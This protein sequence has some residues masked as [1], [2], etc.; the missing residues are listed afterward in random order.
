MLTNSMDKKKLKDFIE[1]GLSQR[2]IAKK[3]GKSQSTVRHWLDKYEITKPVKQI[4]IQ[5]CSFCGSKIHDKKNPNRSY[6]SNQCQQLAQREKAISDGVASHRSLKTHLIQERG[7][8]CEICKI[9]EWCGE[10]APLILDHVD[11]NSENNNI[12]NLRLVC[13]NCD[14]QLPTYK[15]KNKGNGRHNRRQR[16]EIGKSY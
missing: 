12:S 5:S 14:M 4:K 1:Q 3:T 9:T 8:Q 2:D 6:C 15:N 7:H 16:Y 10:P 11:G 13:G